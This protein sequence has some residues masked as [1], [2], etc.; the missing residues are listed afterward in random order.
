MLIRSSI[1]PQINAPVRAQQPRFKA[2]EF[3][4]NY[5][6]HYKNLPKLVQ[7]PNEIRGSFITRESEHFRQNNLKLQKALE[8]WVKDNG[9]EDE[10]SWHSFNNA[11]YSIVHCVPLFCTRA[12]GEKL[13]E[14]FKD[15]LDFQEQGQL[16]PN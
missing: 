10:A 1:L 14:A 11:P 15:E 8:K 4:T 6:V 12:L 16:R 9:L 13:Q 3:D 7:E 2:I 5:F